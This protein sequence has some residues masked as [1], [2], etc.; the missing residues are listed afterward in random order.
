[1]RDFLRGVGYTLA[2]LLLVAYVAVVSAALWSMYHDDHWRLDHLES[3]T[4]NTPQWQTYM[5][6]TDECKLFELPLRLKIAAD[7]LGA[8]VTVKQ[9]G[10]GYAGVVYF[11]NRE[12]SI[13][14][15]LGCDARAMVLAHELGHIL[16]P[17]AVRPEGHYG[18]EEVFAEAVS[19][20]VTSHERDE[21]SVYAHY[22]ADHKQDLNV[23]TVYRREIIFAANF[24][25]GE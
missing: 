15:S 12:I 21:T 23:L 13:D 25:W 14:A 2:G 11:V 4:L 6:T 19:Y 20:L 9:P 22:L 8:K 3:Q 7:R 1:M 24:I 17:D 16:E 10:K 5:P 18:E